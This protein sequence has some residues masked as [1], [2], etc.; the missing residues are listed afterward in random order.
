MRGGRGYMDRQREYVPHCN[1]DRDRRT[2]SVVVVMSLR[3]RVFLVR[4]IYK[5][6]LC[7]LEETGLAQV[8]NGCTQSNQ[9]LDM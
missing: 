5:R 4:S 3:K 6:I 7:V 2:V 8:Q 9:G 1:S